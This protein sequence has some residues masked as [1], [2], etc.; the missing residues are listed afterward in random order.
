MLAGAKDVRPSRYGNIDE[1][2]PTLRRR[3]LHWIRTIQ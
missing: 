3:A 1:G 2:A